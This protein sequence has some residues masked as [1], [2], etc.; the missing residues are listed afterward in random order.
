MEPA[1]SELIGLVPLAALLDV[2]DRIG[3]SPGL[4]VDE[5]LAAAAAYLRLRDFSPSMVLERRLAAAA[6]AEPR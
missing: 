4:P 1:E 6:A 3:S 5:R 2:A